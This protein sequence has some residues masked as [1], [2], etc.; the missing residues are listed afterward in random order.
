MTLVVHGF[1]IRFENPPVRR[2][3]RLMCPAREILR[4]Q[5]IRAKASLMHHSQHVWFTEIWVSSLWLLTSVPQIPQNKCPSFGGLPRGSVGPSAALK[6]L[7]LSCLHSMCFGSGSSSSSL[8]LFMYSPSVCLCSVFC[9]WFCLLHLSSFQVLMVER[10]SC[11]SGFI[12]SQHLDDAQ[13]SHRSYSS[14]MCTVYNV[15]IL[16]V[17]AINLLSCS[18]LCTWH[19]LH[20][21]PSWN[22]SLLCCFSLFSH[23][24]VFF[25]RFE[26]LRTEHKAE[27]M[28]NSL[29]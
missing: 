4:V 14:L 2:R 19:L 22:G 18:V 5:T 15:V 12:S 28:S 10:R 29:M 16:A 26:G 6:P 9:V 17:H 21:C 1:K 3:H 13:C 11:G 20:L 27:Q 23:W 25:L 8:F 7:S 24:R